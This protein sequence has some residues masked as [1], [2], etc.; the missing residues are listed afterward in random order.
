ML[1]IFSVLQVILGHTWEI[2]AKGSVSYAN[3]MCYV[4]DTGPHTPCFSVQCADYNFMNLCVLAVLSTHHWL[5]VGLF[6]Q[7]FG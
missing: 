2:E 6:L 7:W 1:Y 5:K 4:S 3:V